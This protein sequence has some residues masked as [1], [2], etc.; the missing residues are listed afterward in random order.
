MNHQKTKG[1]KNTFYKLYYSKNKPNSDLKMMK[2][3]MNKGEIH[4]DTD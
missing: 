4:D 1:K 2:K 3:R